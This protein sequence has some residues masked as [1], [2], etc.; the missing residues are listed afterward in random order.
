MTEAGIAKR[1]KKD[2]PK[3]DMKS[4]D[5]KAFNPYES[6]THEDA[7][8]N[9]LSKTKSVTMKCYLLYIVHPEVS[10]VIFTYDFEERMFQMSFT[11]QE[12]NIDHRTLYTKLKDVLI[13][14]TG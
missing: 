5:L 11:G 14:S 8:C 13:G 4:A 9:L 6:E 2:K 3:A 1:N 10:L 12:Y 7:F